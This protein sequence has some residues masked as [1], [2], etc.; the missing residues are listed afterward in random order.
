M[1]STNDFRVGLVFEYEG[2]IFRV[3]EWSHI[4]PGKGIAFVQ[5]KLRNL[6]T[7]A[8]V[9]KRLRAGEKVNDIRLEKREHQFLYGSGDEYHFLDVNNYEEVTL[10]REHIGKIADF[11]GENQTIYIEIMQGEVLGA[12]LPPH[13]VLKVVSTE[14]GV[15]GN[16]VS[17]TTKPAKVETGAV[18]QVP[19]F[20]ENGEKIKIDT[21][22]FS[23]VERI[24]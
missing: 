19:L 1:I 16:T 5:T 21:R 13:I 18:V 24:R 7:G 8:I 23:Y 9:D 11:L 10:T 12:E 17:N 20:V 22:D 2:E 6:R 14:P 3:V 15:R 4:K